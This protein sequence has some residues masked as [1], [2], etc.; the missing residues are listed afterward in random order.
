MTGAPV[1]A[2]DFETHLIGPDPC[3]CGEVHDQFPPAVCMSYA[4]AG[5]EDDGERAVV[6]AR[7]GIPLLLQALRAGYTMVG[8]ETAFDVFVACINAERFSIQEFDELI[9][10][11]TAA[12]EEGRVHDVSIRQ[13]LL[14][15]ANGSYRWLRFSDGRALRI[16]YDLATCAKRNTD[17]ELDKSGDTW[18]LKYAL[19]DGVPI[20][21]WPAEAVDY[22]LLDAVATLETYLAQCEWRETK[23]GRAILAR[24]EG[25]SAPAYFGELDPLQ[26]AHAQTCHALWLKATS[27]YGIRTDAVAL[28]KFERRTR[29]DYIRLCEQVRRT[30]LARRK[31]WRDRVRMKEAGC[32]YNKNAEWKQLCAELDAELP[33]AEEIWTELAA[34]GL[35]KSKHTRNMKAAR[36][37]MFDVCL[38]K[39]KK[40]PRTDKYDPDSNNPKYSQLDSCIAIDSDACRLSE[41]DWLIAYSELTHVSKMI[42]T[43]IPQLRAGVERPIH[44]HYEVCLETGRTS[45]AG[46]NI[47]NRARGEKDRAGDRE[48]FAPPE[49][50]V[51][52]D[53]DYAQLELYCLSQV[54]KWVLGYSTIGDVLL[55]NRD[56]HT[57]FA[58]LIVGAQLGRVVTYDEGKA[59]LKLDGKE[60]REKSPIYALMKNGRDAAKGCN[61]GRPGGLGAET[62]VSYAARSYGVVLPQEKWEELLALWDTQWP[63][64]PEYFE[65]INSLET[66]PRS[67]DFNVPQAWSGRLRGGAT[68]CAACNSF[69]QGLG[70]DVA[71]LAGWYLFKACFVPGVD[72]ELFGCRP[73]NFIHDQFLVE[74]EE[75]RAAAAAKR[76][77][78]WCG[79]AAAEVLPDY[80]WK[81]AEKSDAIL[82]RRWSKMAE[83]TVDANGELVAWEDARLFAEEMPG[84][85]DEED[86]ADPLTVAA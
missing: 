34:A 65:F 12:Y 23:Q 45:S 68:Y 78:Y 66:A 48:C 84:A 77:E 10:E 58:C 24:W 43:D 67:G 76:V 40:I 59:A 36:A 51:Y 20:D 46:P 71:K 85:D 14:D 18:R 22:A 70:A 25:Y 19:L 29:L 26:D 61:F 17:L 72:P 28:D 80:G 57:A 5:G 42:S 21:Q 83:K 62:M 50:F 79:R 55:D 33:E 44:T 31:Y 37:R 64:M 39:H 53:Y 52:I 2:F 86:A 73:V 6:S 11:W 9:G 27:G 81:M 15:L 69:Y 63:E 47:Q 56:P 1:F 82:C 32:K 35:V 13:K 16:A 3:Q 60:G 38:A 75:A 7:D 41:D 30:G 49:G 74:A 8:A 54:C 4:I